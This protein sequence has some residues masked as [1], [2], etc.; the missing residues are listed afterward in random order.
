MAL[1]PILTQNV[2][3]TVDTIP[4]SGAEIVDCVL[5]LS[6]LKQTRNVEKYSCMS[7]DNEYISVGSITRDNLTMSTLYAE[8]ATDGQS[9]LYEAFKSNAKVSIEL[10]FKDNEDAGTGHGTLITGEARIIS[11]EMTFEKDKAIEA[12]FELG[13][14]GPITIT[15]A[16]DQAP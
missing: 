12:N 3:L 15:K 16:A 1:N 7:N 2:Q 5:S 14:D 6:T 10:D 11:Y 8:E 13:W 9:L 4:A